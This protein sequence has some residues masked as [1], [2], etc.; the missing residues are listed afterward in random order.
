MRRWLT[1][2][3]AL[4]CGLCADTVPSGG[5]VLELSGAAGWKKYRC[6]RCA[7]EPFTGIRAVPGAVNDGLRFSARVLDIAHTTRGKLRRD[8]KIAQGGDE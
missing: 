8:F 6:E 2:N 5:H 7:D 4:Y 3:G 1:S